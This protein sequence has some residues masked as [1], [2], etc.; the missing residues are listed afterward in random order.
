M[1][2]EFVCEFFTTDSNYLMVWDYSYFLEWA[3]CFSWHLHNRLNYTCIKLFIRCSLLIS[4]IQ[5]HYW[6][7]LLIFLFLLPN[8]IQFLSVISLSP[9]KNQLWVLKIYCMKWCAS[10]RALNKTLSCLISTAWRFPSEAISSYQ[11][12][13]IDHGI[14]KRCAQLALL[15]QYR[16]CLTYQYFI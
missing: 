7:K 13:T 8:P 16:Q 4:K 15:R 12:D 11:C 14:G 2:V 9:Q 10:E 6:Y 3:S 5:F 1:D